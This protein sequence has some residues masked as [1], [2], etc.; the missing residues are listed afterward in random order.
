MKD[1]FSNLF[2]IT[3]IYFVLKSNRFCDKEK[4][5]HFFTLKSEANKNGISKY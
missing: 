3:K 1:E 5:D 4:V 2:P